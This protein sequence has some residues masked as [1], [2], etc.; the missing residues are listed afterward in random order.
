M[1]ISSIQNQSL[2][3]VTMQTKALINTILAFI[4]INSAFAE[5]SKTLVTSIYGG[6]GKS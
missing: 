5:E 6:G 3:G 1:I 4:F 2:K